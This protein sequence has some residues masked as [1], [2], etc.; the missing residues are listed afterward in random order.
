MK[1]NFKSQAKK[2]L[3]IMP[4]QFTSRLEFG[5]QFFERFNERPVEYSYV[6]KWLQQKST[7]LATNE[8][9]S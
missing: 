6:F 7:N 1:K 2:L 4:P 5:R 8:L 9:N 3:N